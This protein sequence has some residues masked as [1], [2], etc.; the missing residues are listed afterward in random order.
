VE[1][2][3]FLRRTIVFPRDWQALA[4][5]I[6]DARDDV[7]GVVVTLGTDTL[8]HAAA[9]LALMLPATPTAVVLTGAMTPLRA[10]DG[11]ARRNLEGAACV[12]LAAPGGIYVVFDGQILRGA[13]VT[14]TRSAAAAA[15][16]SPNEPPLGRVAGGRI[17]WRHRPPLLPSGAP[18]LASQL[19]TRVAT[20]TLEP[21]TLPDDL[22]PFARFRGL[23]VEGYGD[24]NVPTELVPALTRLLRGR[25][26][27]LASRCTYGAL[28][29]RYEGGAALVGAGAL[30]AGAMTREM[31]SV[32]LMWALGQ[33]RNLTAAR[34][35]FRAGSQS[36]PRS[37]GHL[38]RV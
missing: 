1:A 37:R 27:V 13:S 18:R 15:F 9:A 23:L 28:H 8:A 11:G 17:R 12:A 26:V 16:E 20:I 24:G 6:F 32:R 38:K 36:A 3:D 19:D 22:A 31:A 29:H 33:S 30:S 5:A 35:L 34:Q 7:D 14:K 21:Q 25:L 2:R 4:A 10:A